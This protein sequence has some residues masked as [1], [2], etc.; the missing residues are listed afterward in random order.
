[1]QTETIDL[2]DQKAKRLGSEKLRQQESSGKQRATTTNWEERYKRLYSVY[3][4]LRENEREMDDH[5]TEFIDE[6][7]Q[8]FL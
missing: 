4:S 7:S 5:V 2:L 3:L 8:A 6:M 1:V